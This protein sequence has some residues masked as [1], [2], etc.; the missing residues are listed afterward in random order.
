MYVVVRMHY[1]L[2]MEDFFF[3]CLSSKYPLVVKFYLD[4]H[5]S[6]QHQMM[7]RIP[8]ERKQEQ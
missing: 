4:H 1:V 7:T 5:R 2:S 3:F 8:L 6:D